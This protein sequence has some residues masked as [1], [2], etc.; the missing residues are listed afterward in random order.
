MVLQGYFRGE[1]NLAA[2][3]LATNF[4]LQICSACSVPSLLFLAVYFIPRLCNCLRTLSFLLTLDIGSFLSDLQIVC[5]LRL[6]ESEVVEVGEVIDL[7]LGLGRVVEERLLGEGI[8]G[9]ERWEVEVKHGIP[10]KF[11]GDLLYS[12]N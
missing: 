12:T 9:V 1:M 2:F 6:T 5:S 11:I 10:F 8:E 4:F 7:E 3:S